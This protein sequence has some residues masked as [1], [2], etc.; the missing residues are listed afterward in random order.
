MEQ[1]NSSTNAR[2]KATSTEPLGPCHKH[3]DWLVPGSANNRDAQFAATVVDVARGTRVIAS[4]LSSHLTDLGAIDSGA[5]DSVRMLLSESDTSSLAR[6][7]V[8]S[9]DQLYALAEGRV[10]HFNAQAAAGARA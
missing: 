9:L 7:A 6:L 2:Q 10:D 5:G 3:D 4:I 1:L 8:F